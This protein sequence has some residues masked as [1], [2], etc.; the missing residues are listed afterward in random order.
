MTS[1]GTIFN[2]A[3]E[4]VA[5]HPKCCQRAQTLAEEDT[6]QFVEDF[7]C[8]LPHCLSVPKQEPSVTRLLQFVVKF[9]TTTSAQ[10]E[11]TP[12]EYIPFWDYLLHQLVAYT[13]VSD[14]SIRWRTC[15]LIGDMLKSLPAHCEMRC[16]TS[17]IASY[18]K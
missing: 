1:L 16:V 2:K 11:S 4:T 13:T 15:N 17:L 8:F 10:V 9:A 3:Q 18:D 7:F 12:G 14:K 5:S 6:D